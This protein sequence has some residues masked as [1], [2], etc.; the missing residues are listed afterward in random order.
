MAIQDTAGS[1]T[2]TEI[3]LRVDT[4]ECFF[5]WASRE[6]SCRL[7]LEHLV[8]RSGGELLEF[9]A[10]DGAEPG[11]VVQMADE[12]AAIAEAR[13]LREALDGGLVQLI[14]TG[15][16]V[17]TTLADAGAVTR[18]VT[19]SEGTGRVVANVPAHADV[20]TVVE[21]FRSRHP[22]SQ[23]LAS[24]R[25]SGS[26]PVR[27]ERG[28]KGALAAHLTDRQIE[29]FRTAYLGGYFEWPRESSSEECA[30]MLG[31]SQP[32]FSQHMRAIQRSMAECLFAS[33][34]PRG[35]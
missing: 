24:R 20:R 14:V 35:Y 15:P 30:Q 31:I 16:C 5:V 10:V 25:G 1:E 9:F 17:T 12:V 4:G 7:S 22:G 8:H 33:V 3:E 13:I 32:T 34:P 6:A 11:D 21:T 28:L 18:S 2:A 29:V 23:L 19:A 26:I 27:S